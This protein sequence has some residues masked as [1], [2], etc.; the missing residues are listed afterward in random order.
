MSFRV[1]RFSGPPR[2][3]G[4][5]SHQTETWRWSAYL[6]NM[7]GPKKIQWILSM[8]SITYIYT[9][10]CSDLSRWVKS[11]LGCHYEVAT[12]RISWQPTIIYLGI[13]LPQNTWFTTIYDRLTFYNHLHP[14]TCWDAPKKNWQ[15]VSEPQND[16]FVD[17]KA[18]SWCI[19]GVVRGTPNPTISAIRRWGKYV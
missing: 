8:L 17:R 13:C 7:L 10:I 6:K 11:L 18:H 9:A 15:M 4:F 12:P 19:Q 16:D 1:T 2:G 3:S 14:L 5:T